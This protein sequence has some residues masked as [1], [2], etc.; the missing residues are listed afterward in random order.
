MDKQVEEFIR[1]L[2]GSYGWMVISGFVLLLF[3]NTIES[4][5]NGMKFFFGNDY[6]IDDI[7]YVNNKKCRIIGQTLFKTTFYIMDE[8]RKFQ[9]SNYKLNEIIIEKELNK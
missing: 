1:Y 5:L 3:K 4:I 2:F 6:N 9:L 7:V 8:N